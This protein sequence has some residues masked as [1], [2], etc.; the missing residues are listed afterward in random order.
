MSGQ[1]LCDRAACGYVTNVDPAG[2][3]VPQ[4]DPLAI[5]TQRAGLQRSSA[6]TNILGQR[7]HFLRGRIQ[8]EAGKQEAAQTMADDGQRQ[9]IGGQSQASFNRAMSLTVEFLI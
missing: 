3:E 4:R 2:E 5:R 9:T 6:Q 1:M 8:V 7:G